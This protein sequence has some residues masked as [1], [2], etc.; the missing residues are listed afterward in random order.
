MQRRFLNRGLSRRG[1]IKGAAT[2]AAVAALAPAG[3]GRLTAAAAQ[4]PTTVRLVSPPSSPA[5]TAALEALLEEFAA[6][7]PNIRV[8]YQ[9]ITSEYN[10]KLQTDLAAGS[11]ADVFTVDSLV[12]PDLIAA[13]VMTPL[14]DYMAQA[15][16]TAA[17]YFPG[18]ISAFQA[19]GRTYGLPKDFS[20]LAMF[21]D[22]QAFEAAGIAAPPATWDEL[23]T[24]AQTLLDATGQPPIVYAPSLAR[25]IAFLYAGGGRILSEDGSQVTINSP[26]AK[27]ALDYFY[28]LYTD[29]L[30]ATFTDVGAVWP[31]AAFAT[32]TGSIVFEGNWLLPFLAE[33]APDKQFR[34]AEMPAG[35][36]GKATMAFTVCYAINEASA[37]RDA[38]WTLVSYL[39]GP[40]G[41]A[42]WSDTSGL[43][44]SRPALTQA[45][46]DKYPDR[47]A[48]LAGGEYARPWQLG[49]GGEKFNLDADAEL[50]A[51]FSGQGS[52]EETLAR[53][54]EKANEDIRLGTAPVATP[55]T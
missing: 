16:F 23:R 36:A 49:Q 54:E 37:V 40:E 21:Y 11:A 22:P 55:A 52:T 45:Y 19:G 50:Q 43:L 38:A 46:V 8:D 42:I 4:E 3:L 33:N 13:E 7:N 12:M 20:T 6:A 48:F 31:G 9:A 25:Y 26:E 24:A 28:G 2:G 32:D 30:A 44:P 29:G 51:L 15:G 53:L 1:L 39:T 34:V 41:M 14:D 35:P 5:E 17:D 10:T 27:T 18:L 47:S